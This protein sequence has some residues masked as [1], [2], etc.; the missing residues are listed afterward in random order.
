MIGQWL[1]G[2]PYTSQIMNLTEARW[3]SRSYAEQQ[4]VLDAIEEKIR[5]YRRIH[6]ETDRW[7]TLS[8]RRRPR[9][10]RS[11]PSPWM[12][13]PD[14]ALE[15]RSMSAGIWS[16]VVRQAPVRAVPDSS[17]ACPALKIRPGEVVVLEVPSG[18][19][20]ST[21]LDLLALAL[22]PDGG[23]TFG[24][25]PEH[26]ESTDLL[27]LWERSDLDGLGRLRGAHI[28]YV[29]QTGGLLSF[30]TARENIALSCRLLGRDPAGRVERLA[31]RLSI[32][33]PSSTRARAALG[34]GAPAGRHRPGHG[35]P[36]ERAPGG[37]AHGL[38]GPAS[39]RSPSGSCSWT[40]C[41]AP[42]SRQ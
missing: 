24:F 25:R 8:R 16:S 20:K 35:P 29:L 42:G 14:V 21:L 5:L 11:P 39:M 10:R 34:G 15:R 37:R 7:V 19:G 33:H 9:A 30:L 27:R 22:K 4:E 32:C 17:C 38:R 36:A 40:W 3:L 41:S 28:G 2:L 31:E 1:D 18:C 26:P 6:D 13:C 12:R 23:E